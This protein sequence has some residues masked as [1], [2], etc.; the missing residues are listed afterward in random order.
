MVLDENAIRLSISVNQEDTVIRLSVMKRDWPKGLALMEEILTEPKFD[1]DILEVVKEQALTA[2]KRQGGDAHAV[3]MREA[4]V[5]HF[6]NHP[7]GRDPLRGLKTIPKISK[8]DLMEFLRTYFVPSNMV[9][10]VAGDLDKDAAVEGL[11]QLFRALPKTKA[12]KRTLED[13]PETPPVIALIHKPG[14]VQ[15]QVTIALRGIKRTHPDYWKMN[16]LM[17][18]FGGSDSMIFTR[19]R[20]D[21]GL[22][23]AAYFYQTYK[24]EAGLMVGY[25]GCRGEKTAMA[26]EET[27]KIMNALGKE[28][29]SGKLEQKRLD[30]LNS[31]VFNVDT[32]AELVEV[33]SRYYMRNEP[34]DTLEKIQVAYLSAE[35]KELQRLARDILRTRK[36]QVFVVADKTLPVNRKDGSVTTLEESLKRLAQSLDLPYTEIPLR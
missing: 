6:E 18:L 36:L 10:S 2:L 30:A 1:D 23:Y 16:L 15:S 27:V 29:P 35:P 11:A 14:Q 25:I 12:P 3:S 33:Y 31:F 20:D 32:P 13:P 5:W 26:V 19:L 21:L 8:N 4:M 17:N 24:W 9:A 34:L 28:V 22:V 7:Y